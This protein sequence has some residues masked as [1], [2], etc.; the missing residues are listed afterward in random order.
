MKINQ[1]VYQQQIFRVAVLVMML[2]GVCSFHLS[3]KQMLSASQA[4]LFE[5]SNKTWEAGS[6]ALFSLLSSG[7]GGRLLAND[8]EA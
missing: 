2:S 1:L 8:E 5:L 6:Y 7:V 3:S 4:Q